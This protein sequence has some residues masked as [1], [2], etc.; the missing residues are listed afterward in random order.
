[1][2]FRLPL[3]QTPFRQPEKQIERLASGR[4]WAGE[5][6]FQAAYACDAA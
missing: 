1:M 2:V 3:G 4:C 6:D 5:I